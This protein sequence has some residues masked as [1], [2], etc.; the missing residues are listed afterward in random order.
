MDRVDPMDNM[1]DCH[2]KKPREIRGLQQIR[3]FSRKGVGCG[4][5]KNFFSREK[6]FFPS[7]QCHLPLFRKKGLFPG[8]AGFAGEFAGFEAGGKDI[9]HV[10][11]DKLSFGLIT[12]DGVFKNGDF[13]FFC[14]HF[15]TVGMLCGNTQRTAEDT[16]T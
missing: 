15:N 7:P 10:V 5:G 6:R 4:E 12:G 13:E 1:D 14:Q 3:R 11:K 9:N 16:L 2:K 8:D